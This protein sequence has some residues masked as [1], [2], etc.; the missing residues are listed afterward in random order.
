MLNG[1][2][3]G[4]TIG[5]NNDRLL[6]TIEG[7]KEI[8]KDK[9]SISAY[10]QKRFGGFNMFSNVEA[11]LEVKPIFKPKY[12]IYLERHGKPPDG[13]YDQELLAQIEKELEAENS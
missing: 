9:E 8:L 5:E 13:R 11:K 1:L 3:K 12:A 6:N 2:L 10:L 4:I 7:Y